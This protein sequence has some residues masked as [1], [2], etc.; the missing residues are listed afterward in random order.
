MT[1]TSSYVKSSGCFL[2]LRL[3]TSF[4]LV[5]PFPWGVRPILPHRDE[6]SAPQEKS[7]SHGCV[8]HVKMQHF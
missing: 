8:L 4:A 5:I 2:E 6:G 1:A 7:L 3:F